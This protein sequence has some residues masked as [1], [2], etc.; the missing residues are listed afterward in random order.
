MEVIPS[1]KISNNYAEVSS[2]AK[3][4][5]EPII[6]TKNGYA[7]GVYMS[8]ATYKKQNETIKIHDTLLDAELELQASGELHDLGESFSRIRK[9]LE[10]KANG[11]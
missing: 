6:L 9:K 3:K 11:K 8:I 4:I 10:A 5:A 2:L 7:D 1:S